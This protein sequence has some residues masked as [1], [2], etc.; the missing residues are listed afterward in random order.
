MNFAVDVPA[1]QEKWLSAHSLGE[2]LHDYLSF[3]M[4]KA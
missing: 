4:E 3:T 1:R 2:R